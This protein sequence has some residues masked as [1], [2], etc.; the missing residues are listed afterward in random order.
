MRRHL[1]AAIIPAAV[2]LAPAAQ[3]ADP[4][5]CESQHDIDK[6]QLL[7]RLSLDLRSRIP[8]IEEYEALDEQDD[9]SIET[10][11]SFLEGDDF[12]LT[13]RQYHERLFWPNIIPAKIHDV[14]TLLTD[15]KAPYAWRIY[16][17]VRTKAMRGH[18]NAG[19][20][21]FEQTHFDPAY[22]GEFRPDPAYVLVD[23]EGIRHEGW[24]WVKPFWSDDP[25]FKIKVCAYDAQETLSV[26]TPGNVTECA[27]IAG[28]KLQQCGCGPGLRSC[29]PTNFL[30][31][32][33]VK[34]SLREQLNLLVDEVTVGGKPYTDIMLSTK[35][36]QDGK[37]A[38]WKKHLAPSAELNITY[39]VPDPSEEVLDKGY[40]DTTW[41]EVER[42]PMHA[43]VL[44]L[45]I[46]LLRFQ[47]NR[48]R[49]DRFRVNFMCQYFIPPEKLNPTPGCSETDADITQRCN[50]QYCHQIL[51][52]LASHFGLFAEA[53]TTLMSDTSVFPKSDPACADGTPTQFCR[54]FYVTQPDIHGAGALAPYQFADTHPDFVDNIEQGPRKLAMEAIDSGVFA[55][56]AVKRVF[57]HFH[58]RDMAIVGDDTEEIA[59]LEKLADEFESTNYDLRQLILR[60]VTLPQYRRIH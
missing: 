36:K 9:V 46:F 55:R 28:R 22:P 43:G 32:N 15:T 18:A 19:C 26:A 8:S 47:T 40:F 17:G 16:S 12:R 48:S 6:Y 41:T 29:Y 24:R 7:R 14:E 23:A 34:A 49:G 5:T 52:P 35:A 20:D 39:N 2:L 59:L 38:F 21:D 50:C 42:G 4:E 37:I 31:D 33:A 11:Q 44:T 30:V 25:N 53:G 1:L 60:V 45:P 10:I 27:S 13:M 56:C 3:A 54:R 58:K 57:S 51:E